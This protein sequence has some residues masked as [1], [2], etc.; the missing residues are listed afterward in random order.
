MLP[1]TLETL[2][3]A[4]NNPHPTFFHAPV[5]SSPAQST[6]HCTRQARAHCSVPRV[7][8]QTGSFQR[9]TKQVRALSDYRPASRSL[10][11][12][13][14]SYGAHDEA[15]SQHAAAVHARRTEGNRFTRMSCRCAPWRIRH[16]LSSTSSRRLARR[17]G[18]SR[19][20]SR[21]T[22]TAWSRRISRCSVSTSTCSRCTTG[23]RLTQ[24]PRHLFLPGIGKELQCSCS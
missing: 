16:A 7:S 24:T 6:E 19:S 15:D 4:T 8:Q 13:L 23:M 1:Y 9:V 18:T 10:L 17:R 11:R 12:P 22:S 5:A 14:H 21:R 3:F 20:S 2:L